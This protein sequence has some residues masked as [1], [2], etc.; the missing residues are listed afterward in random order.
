M[1]LEIERKFLVKKELWKPCGDGVRIAQGYLCGDPE[2][3]VRVRVKGDRGYLTVKGKNDG[4]SRRE[5]EYEIPREDAEAMLGL[6]G[7]SVIDKMRYCEPM[8]QHLWEVDV[9]LGENRG[10]L[11]A[12]IELSHEDEP[13][14]K[15][16]WLGD[17]VSGD[18][19]YYNSSL[20]QKPYRS[21][22]SH[23]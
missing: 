16:Q 6:C 15:P 8:E 12:E 4:I 22:S 10:L 7:C 11:L 19:R 13:F 18:P 23:S 17:E 5:F 2:R 20:S 9:F 1:A 14:Q 21:W 3:T